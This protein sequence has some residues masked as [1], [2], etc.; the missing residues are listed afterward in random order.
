MQKK[1]ELLLEVLGKLSKAGVLDDTVIIGS[2]CMHF[3]KELFSEI[4]YHPTIRT[5]DIDLLVPLPLK[6]KRKI[7]V[8]ALLEADGFIV[9]HNRDGFLRLEH[10]DLIVE[11]LVPERG[12]GSNQ[13]YP[14]PAFG[15]NAQPLRFLDYLAKNCIDVVS[16]GLKVRVPAPAAFGLH[17]LIVS[18]RR[19]TEVKRIKEKREALTVLNAMIEEGMKGAILDAYSAMLPSWQKKVTAALDP[20][21]DD[22][23]FTLLKSEVHQSK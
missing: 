12:K 4:N 19:K 7:D 3:Y 6:T 5:R 13:P 10:P 22:P 15:M 23:I 18:A 9:I 14:L 11:F 16:D 17:K 20:Q 8:A 2:W 1:Y 21:E